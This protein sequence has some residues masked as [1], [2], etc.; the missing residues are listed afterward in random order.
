MGYVTL[1]KASASTMSAKNEMK[2]EVQD[3]IFMFKRVGIDVGPVCVCRLIR[4]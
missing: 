2:N 4:L 3:N 1:A